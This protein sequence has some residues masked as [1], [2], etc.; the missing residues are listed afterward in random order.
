MAHKSNIDFN[1]YTSFNQDSNDCFAAFE[2]LKASGIVFNHLHYFD[3]NQQVETVKN[4][5][6]WFPDLVGQ[7]KFPFVTYTEIYDAT[8]IPVTVAK[9]V[10]GKE[11]IKATDWQ[12]LF[13]FKG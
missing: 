8:D 12:Q 10:I 1:L 7:I 3:Q 9:I 13:N 5:E 2:A 6:T 4:L 11:K